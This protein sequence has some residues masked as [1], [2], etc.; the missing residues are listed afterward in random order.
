VDEAKHGQF[1]DNPNRQDILPSKN[2]RL[3]ISPS[4]AYDPTRDRLLWV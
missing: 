3:P 4:L 1:A 2:A